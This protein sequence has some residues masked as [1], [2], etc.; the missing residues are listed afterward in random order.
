MRRAA[1]RRNGLNPERTVGAGARIHAIVESMRRFVEHIEST[2]ADVG[3]L[4]ARKMLLQRGCLHSIS[5]SFCA[6]PGSGRKS[7]NAI[8]VYLCTFVDHGQHGRLAR[9]SHAIQADD[10]FTRKENILYGVTLG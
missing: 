1:L 10:L 5:A 3:L 8:T 7:F 9:S 2:H 6:A 4:A